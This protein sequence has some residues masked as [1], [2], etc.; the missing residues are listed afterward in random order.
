[1]A[2]SF[3]QKPDSEQQLS[4]ECRN[5]SQ[6]LFL[7]FYTARQHLCAHRLP[8]AVVVQVMEFDS[9]KWLAFLGQLKPGLTVAVKQ[10]RRG[11][12]FKTAV[13]SLA[14]HVQLICSLSSCC[15]DAV[16]AH[17]N[18]WCCGVLRAGERTIPSVCPLIKHRI[19]IHSLYLNEH[20]ERQKG[21]VKKDVLLS[22]I[23]L[24]LVSL[25]IQNL[26]FCV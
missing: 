1:M 17:R 14:Q 20:I 19:K 16:S 21:R 24:S 4:W 18:S 22:I 25:S 10:L 3:E 7:R 15:R 13:S 11:A 8:N 6:F 9:G 23:C 12:S 26:I 5:T 2:K